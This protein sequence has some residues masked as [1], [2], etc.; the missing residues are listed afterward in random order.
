[1]KNNINFFFSH[2]K[3]DKYDILITKLSQDIQKNTQP[4]I[5]K[6]E[7]GDDRMIMIVLFILFVWIWYYRMKK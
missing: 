3:M 7:K 5:Q 6:I 2:S 4:I 1:M